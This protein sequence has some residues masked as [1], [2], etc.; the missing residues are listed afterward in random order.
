MLGDRTLVCQ[1]CGRAHWKKLKKGKH[2]GQWR[3]NLHFNVH[4]VNYDNLYKET[5]DD[6]LLLCKSCHDL[7]HA[8]VKAR[9]TCDFYG[10]LASFVESRGFIYKTTN[11]IEE[12]ESE[13]GI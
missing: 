8:V 6:V 4:H 5:R 9:N 11:S 13:N 10:Q 12:K 7:C 2:K 3:A 1:I